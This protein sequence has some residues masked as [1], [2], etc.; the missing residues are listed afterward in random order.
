MKPET[1][2][3]FVELWL[4]WCERRDIMLWGQNAK[5]LIG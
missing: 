3:V 5:L 1:S 4:S 2:G